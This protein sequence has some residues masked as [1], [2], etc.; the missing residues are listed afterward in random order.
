MS[1]YLEIWM[2]KMMMSIIRKQIDSCRDGTY[3]CKC[4]MY[5]SCN[6]IA[7]RDHLERYEEKIK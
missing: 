7:L 1:V 3:C 4:H 6:Y 5:K 2:F